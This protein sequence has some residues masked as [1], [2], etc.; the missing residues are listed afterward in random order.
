[1]LTATT[2]KVVVMFDLLIHASIPTTLFSFAH[3]S[4]FTFIGNFIVVRDSAD[5]INRPRVLA[6]MWDKSP[7]DT[8]GVSINLRALRTEPSVANHLI[9]WREERHVQSLWLDDIFPRNMEHNRPEIS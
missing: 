1:M 8:R 7:N 6:S 5:F 9:Y 4:Y 3:L 2:L